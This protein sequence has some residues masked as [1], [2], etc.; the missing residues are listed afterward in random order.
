MAEA[1]GQARVRDEVREAVS[2]A[3]QAGAAVVCEPLLC[4]LNGG[5]QGQSRCAALLVLQI[6]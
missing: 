1:Q 3:Q 2:A 6:R 4:A 5:L